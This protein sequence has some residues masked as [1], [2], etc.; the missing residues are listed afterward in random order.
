ALE[1]Y[2]EI[3]RAAVVPGIEAVRL[4]AGRRAD[5]VDIDADAAQRVD[6]RF[7]RGAGAGAGDDI[8]A[9]QLQR[10]QRLPSGRRRV[11]WHGRQ[12]PA[13]DGVRGGM[14]VVEQRA[15]ERAAAR[16]RAADHVGELARDVEEAAAVVAQVEH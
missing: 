4:A 6:D 1:L 12:R 14:L 16:A 10:R 11:E 5:L 15:L 2:R 8:D 7:A 13:G 9:R 3:R